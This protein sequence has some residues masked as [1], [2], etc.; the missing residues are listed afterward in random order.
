[1]ATTKKIGPTRSKAKKMLKDGTIRGKRLTP[2]QKK[3]FGMIA[4]GKRAT[5][6]KR[7]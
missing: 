4:G 3:L 7:K 1:M 2:G 5:K 6:M